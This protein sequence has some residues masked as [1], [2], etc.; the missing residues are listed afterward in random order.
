MNP[1][2]HSIRSL[3]DVCPFHSTISERLTDLTEAVENLATFIPE[4]RP[5]RLTPGEVSGE[6][7]RV[8]LAT[9]TVFGKLAFNHGDKPELIVARIFTISWSPFKDKCSPLAILRTICLNKTKS[10]AFL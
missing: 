3:G 8:G 4:E 1:R 10:M 2:S 9:G 6:V 5:F 7:Y